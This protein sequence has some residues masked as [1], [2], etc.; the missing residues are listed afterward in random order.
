[1][2]SFVMENPIIIT[3]GMV[4]YMVAVVLFTAITTV[5]SKKDKKYERITKIVVGL[6]GV[7][8]GI[9]VAVVMVWIIFGQDA[10]I[11]I[12]IIISIVALEQLAPK[13][14]KAIR[15][16]AMRIQVKDE[17]IYIRD[18]P[19]D[20]SPAVLSYLA[21]Q[22]IEK[23]KDFVA[24]VLNL[25]AKKVIEIKTLDNGEILIK[26][27][28]SSSKIELPADEKY[29]YDWLT[30][31]NKEGKVEEWEKSVIRQCET[32]GFTKK[33]KRKMDKY[34]VSFVLLF[35]SFIALKLVGAKYGAEDI[36][37]VIYI[38]MFFSFFGIAIVN[39]I[40][41]KIEKG[42]DKYEIYT[43]IGALE[44]SRWD[45]FKKFLKDYTLV[46]EASSESIIVLEQYLAY[47]MALG[48][49][50]E[51]SNEVFD[52]LKS[53]LKYDLIEKLEGYANNIGTD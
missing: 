16:K 43:K 31:I 2:M 29:L 18:V 50:K 44:M 17:Q 12:S 4:L 14:P 32:H 23:R 46:S 36:T 28:S 7:V 13:I 37:L 26:E 24:S 41:G 52:S 10:A 25:V 39:G 42:A 11:V 48:V 47:G 19:A 33:I 8:L 9:I 49:N 15:N 51:Y 22:K 40:T 27:V 6:N 20:Y 53:L 1:M 21:N 34:K 5:L 38:I 45:K 30:G 3:M 35:I